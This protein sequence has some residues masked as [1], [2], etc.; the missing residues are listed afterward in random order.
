MEAVTGTHELEAVAKRLK[1][2]G[3]GDLRKELLKGIRAQGKPAIADVKKSARSTL[4]ARGGFADLVARSSYGTRTRLGGNSVGV[5]IVGTSRSVKGLRAIN[6][7][8]LRHPV[9]GNRDVWAE[10]QIKPGFFDGPIEKRADDI[11][12]GINK[13]LADIAKK[14]ERGAI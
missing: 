7:G 1:A 8:R 14:V 11:R 3:R 5:S 9:Y 6:A 12:R 13:V 10:Q 4:P 2:V